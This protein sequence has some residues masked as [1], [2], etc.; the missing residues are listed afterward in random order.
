MPRRTLAATIQPQVGAIAISSGTGNATSQ[1]QINSRRRPSRS[2]PTPAAR[3]V[4]D[5]A[6]PKATMNESTAALDV[7]PNS[8]SPIRGRVERS[9]P[10][11]APTKALTATSSENCGEVLAQPERGP[12]AT[13][14]SARPTPGRRGWRRRSRPG[15]P[16]PAGCRGRV[17]RRTRPRSR[18]GPPRCDGARSRSSRRDGRRAR[19]RRPSRSSARGRA[20]GGQAGSAGAR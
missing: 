4:S 13:T 15:A 8:S 3:F 11:I 9:S 6:R 19:A 17:P 1:P 5:L 14:T 18:T 20:G 12:R 2:A 16:E 7:R 10:T